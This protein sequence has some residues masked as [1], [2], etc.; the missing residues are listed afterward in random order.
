MLFHKKKLLKSS[1]LEKYD[2][3]Q[4]VISA[5]LDHQRSNQTMKLRESTQ[6]VNFRINCI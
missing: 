3:S 6:N 1:F 4:Y 2:N 5:N